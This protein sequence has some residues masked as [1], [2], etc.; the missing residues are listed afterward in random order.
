VCVDVVDLGDVEMPWGGA[1]H[2]VRAIWQIADIDPETGKRFDVAKWYTVNMHPRSTLRQDLE[3]WRARKFSDAEAECGIDLES[4]VGRPAF[5]QV[6]HDVG[7][8]GHT[9]A[10]VKSVMP[11]PKAT[12]P[13]SP[14]YVRQADRET[15]TTPRRPAARISTTKPVPRPVP[16]V[17][18][19]PM[20][21]AIE[22]SAAPEDTV[23]VD[24][25]KE[26]DDDAVGF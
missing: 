9:Y 7:D 11:L 8:D 5:L 21:D 13:L 16:P 20:P 12:A 19:T 1:K 23:V 25:V 15:T 3:S 18:D 17:L 6:I 14:D 26:D 2:R 24:F 10:H 22:T 4:I